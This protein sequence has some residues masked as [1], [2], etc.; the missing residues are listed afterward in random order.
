VEDTGGA[1]SDGIPVRSM[2]S[3]SHPRGVRK[4]EQSPKA[5]SGHR[6]GGRSEG[7]STMVCSTT[8]CVGTTT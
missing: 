1:E 4:M 6:L 7:R 3:Y 5:S 8:A 2:T